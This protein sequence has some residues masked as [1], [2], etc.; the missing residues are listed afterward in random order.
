[1]SLL[2]PVSRPIIVPLRLAARLAED[3]VEVAL[4]ALS[5]IRH[6]LRGEEHE[7]EGRGTRD[8]GRESERD[9][10]DPRDDVPTDPGPIDPTPT[11][12]PPVRAAPPLPDNIKTL[13]DED[14]LVAEFGEDGAQEPAGAE[15]RIE[16]PFEGYDSLKV[17]EVR[18]RLAAADREVVAAVVLY[19]SA[20]R[21]RSGVLEDAERRLGRMDAAAR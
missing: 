2:G 17:A 5:Y 8:R 6:E 21:A 10:L 18:D 4:D 13:D 16:P 15:V 19:E 14:E 7:A 9:L 11:E 12:P 3:A 20:G 1:M